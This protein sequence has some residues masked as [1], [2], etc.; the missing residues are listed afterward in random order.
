MK[1]EGVCR[2]CNRKLSGRGMTKHLQSCMSEN[3]QPE[4]GDS[5]IFLIKASAGP[6]WVYFEVNTSSTLGRIDSFL[7]DLWLECCG[8]LSAST[9][10]SVRYYSHAEFLE[11][12]EKGMDVFLKQVISPGAKFRH[13]YDFGTTTELE[14]QC[15]SDRKGKARSK[16]EVIARNDMPEIL[17]DECGK[18]AKE[19]CT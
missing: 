13:E 8:H 18:P 19:I 7:R 10:D 16:I 15:I 14:L 12:G 9:I 5:S 17:C 1:S 6:F 4:Q 11:S 2:L 3:L